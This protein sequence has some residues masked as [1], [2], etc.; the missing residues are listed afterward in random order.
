MRDKSRPTND[1]THVRKIAMA[2]DASRSPQ[3]PCSYGAPRA[4]HS[5]RLHGR[6]TMCEP[7][8]MDAGPVVPQVVRLSLRA[9]VLAP[10]RG[11]LSALGVGA[12]VL[13]GARPGS[14]LLAWAFGAIMVSI[15]LAGDPRG[16]RTTAPEPLP[17]EAVPESWAQIARTD[18]LPS[19]VGVALLT[20]VALV[21]DPVLAAVLAGILG[22][23]ALMTMVSRVQ[24][25]VEERRLGGVLYVERQSKRLYVL[26]PRP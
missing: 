5:M 26:E 21:I 23:M 22:G 7:S 25:A 9:R 10:I 16:R 3:V 18:V 19:T 1:S 2:G 6:Q 17:G 12:A 11:G 14:A 24:V 4:A 8:V 15:V 13:D 20:S